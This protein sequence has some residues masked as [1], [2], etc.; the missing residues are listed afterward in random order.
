MLRRTWQKL[1]PERR[2]EADKVV[3]ILGAW[4]LTKPAQPLSW[5]SWLEEGDFP[6][7]PT[8]NFHR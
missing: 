2:R 1:F 5:D 7:A 8:A 6:G 4:C 3:F